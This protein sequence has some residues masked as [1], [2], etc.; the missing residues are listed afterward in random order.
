MTAAAGRPDFEA[1]RAALAS[2][3]RDDFPF[4]RL[5]AAA[6]PSGGLRHAAV[7]VPLLEKDGDVHVLLTKRRADLRRHAGQVSFPGGMVEPD[8]A[9]TLATA[10]R[11]TREEVGI[12]PASVDVLGRLDDT[13]V[14]VS[15]FHLTPWVG[16]VPHPTALLPDP[17]EV[18]AVLFVRLADLAAPGA[19]R[20]ERHERY[21]ME[22]EVHFYDA[23][24]EVIWGATAR[25]LSRLLS[26]WTSR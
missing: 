16:R 5:D 14:L 22:H 17:A 18:E 3:T 19:H 13:L 6:L 7:L 24:G 25:V 4:H 1:L 2:R 9:D 26:L 20:T 11:E 21:G 8:D 15:G 10:L 23:G 12:D